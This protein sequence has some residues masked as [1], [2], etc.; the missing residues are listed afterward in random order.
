MSFLK[1]I[2]K[3]R[4]GI[5][6]GA[7]KFSKAVRVENRI[8]KVLPKGPLRRGAKRIL[9]ELNPLNKLALAAEVVSGKRSLQSA[10]MDAAGGMALAVRKSAL[11]VGR[12]AFKKRRTNRDHN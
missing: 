5:A 3:F 9:G 8:A 2:K 4:K 11:D 1:K 7:R 10:A 6:K 12:S